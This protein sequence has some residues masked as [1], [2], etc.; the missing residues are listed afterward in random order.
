MAWIPNPAAK[1]LGE[2]ILEAN[3]T[4]KA[5]R[6]DGKSDDITNAARQLDDLL[7]Q[8]PRSRQESA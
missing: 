2:Q 6:R 8:L 1:T 3:A 7:D 4:L 5:A